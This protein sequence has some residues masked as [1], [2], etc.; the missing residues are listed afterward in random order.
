[1]TDVLIRRGEDRETY[2]EKDHVK[3]ETGKL[4]FTSFSSW[5]TQARPNLLFSWQRQMYKN[6]SLQILLRPRNGTGPLTFLLSPT[7][8]NK[9]KIWKIIFLYF[10]QSNFKVPQK[11]IWI[12]GDLL[13]QV[14]STIDHDWLQ[15][16]KHSHIFCCISGRFSSDS[17]LFLFIS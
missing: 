8:Q 11:R 5:D 3:M 6:A 14:N 16:T 7:G 15:S 4:S 1:M 9:C 12:Q 17:W 2:R 13:K 10:S